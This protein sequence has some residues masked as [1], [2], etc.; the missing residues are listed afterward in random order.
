MGGISIN[1]LDIEAEMHDV[2]IPHQVFF[3]LQ[4]Q[5]PLLPGR[6]LAAGVDEIVVSDY[7][8]TDEPFLKIRMDHSG[9]PGRAGSLG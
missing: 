5:Q 7:L 8:G 3:S 2:A 1:I 4:P 9:S 6:R